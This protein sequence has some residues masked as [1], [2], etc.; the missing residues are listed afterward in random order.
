MGSWFERILHDYGYKSIGAFLSSLAPS[1][2]YNG[3]G[4]LSFGISATAVPVEKWL[5]LDWAAFVAL[6]LVLLFELVS[7][8]WASA[9]RKEPLSS[10]KLS[11]FTLK[12][13]SYLIIM[14][15]TNLMAIS[16]ARS[17]KS[18]PATVFD[19]MNSFLV[20]Q[21]VLEQVVSILENVAEISGKPK[22]HWI[23]KLQEKIESFWK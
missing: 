10:K 6:L 5:G 19:W 11:R 9:V 16:Y 4:F 22:T 12:V 15:V 20:I 1:S 13:A 3:I 14:A 17:H 8:V 7:G 2:K 18:L 23:S 21:I